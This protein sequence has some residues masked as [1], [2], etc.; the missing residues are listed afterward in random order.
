MKT[1]DIGFNTWFEQANWPRSFVRTLLFNTFIA[2]FLWVIRFDHNFFHVLI[3]SHCIGLSIHGLFYLA[4][5]ITVHQFNGRFW[6]LTMILATLLGS[7]FGFW[8]GAQIIGFDFQKAV[9]SGWRQ[10][11]SILL[12]SL[13]FS[14]IISY[15][16]YATSRIAQT[17]AA[18]QKE[19]AERLANENKLTEARLQLL[20]AQVEPHFLFNTLANVTSL[21][22]TQPDKARHMLEKFIE[23]LRAT[24]ARTREAES[25]LAKEIVLMRA[26]L[27]IIQIRMGSRLRYSID[28]PSMFN[29]TNFPPMLLQPLVENAVKHGL[30]PKIEGGTL[31][32]SAR[33]KNGRLQLSVEDDGLGFKGERSGGLGL[34]NVRE[35]LAVLYNGKAKLTLEE[36]SPCG[37]RAT[38]ELPTNG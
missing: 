28:I 20:Q 18:I 4:C 16:S 3:V 6:P 24:L 9:L 12:I 33:N 2:V 15:L 34:V 36:C 22:D 21:I 27:D 37:T 29:N 35:R 32:I 1:S 30:E 17:E 38:I 23:Y 10:F 19:R 13:L 31:T 25:S 26:Y 8:L 5:H 11:G 7:L 14:A